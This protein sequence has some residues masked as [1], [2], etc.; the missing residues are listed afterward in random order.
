M[1]IF[2][3]HF[4]KIIIVFLSEMKSLMRGME[5]KYF[6]LIIQPPYNKNIIRAGC[7]KKLQQAPAYLGFCDTVVF[8]NKRSP[9]KVSTVYFGLG[10]G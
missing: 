3:A 8:T 2:Y 9:A 10:S 1:K 5:S 4:M 6:V 7:A